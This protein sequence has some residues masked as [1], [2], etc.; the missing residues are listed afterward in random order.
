MNDYTEL[1]S[2]FLKTRAILLSDHP[3][4]YSVFLSCKFGIPHSIYRYN[5][6]PVALDVHGDVDP[7]LRVLRSDD[8]WRHRH[9]SRPHFDQRV[10]VGEAAFSDDVA[11]LGGHCTL[12]RVSWNISLGSEDVIG[13]SS[14]CSGRCP[15]LTVVIDGT[16]SGN[17]FEG[18]GLPPIMLD[19]L[20]LPRLEEARNIPPFSN[21]TTP[22]WF[23]KLNWEWK[24]FSSH[25]FRWFRWWPW[26][27]VV[28]QINVWST[29][30]QH[31]LSFQYSRFDGDWVVKWRSFV[32]VQG[33]ANFLW[34]P[35]C[36]KLQSSVFFIFFLLLERGRVYFVIQKASLPLYLSLNPSLVFL[37]CGFFPVVSSTS[38]VEVDFCRLILVAALLEYAVIVLLRSRW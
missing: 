13:P 17:E 10:P 2:T 15:V 5:G 6:S 8:C 16:P 3:E 28:H 34:D 31:I 22:D 30:G 33:N 29:W 24:H 20:L 32:S 27:M 21:W 7:S 1:E 19:S 9:R 11:R 35:A 38:Q 36:V 18:I 4:L 14:I 25:R 37:Q 12:R 23:C 26:T